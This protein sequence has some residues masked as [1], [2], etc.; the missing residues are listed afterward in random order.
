MPSAP[1]NKMICGCKGKT[2]N[3][4][5]RRLVFLNLHPCCSRRG[6]VRQAIA[7]SSQPLQDGFAYYM[8]D[9]VHGAFNNL[10][11]DHATVRP[12]KLRNAISPKHQIVEVIRGKGEN[13]LRTIKVVEE[14]ATPYD[15]IYG[16][17]F[18]ARYSEQ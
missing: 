15:A 7:D 12:R 5:E 4:K 8:N 11:F 13:A 14:E 1:I 17:V 2:K 3:Q 6:I 10:L 18:P 16:S 9:G